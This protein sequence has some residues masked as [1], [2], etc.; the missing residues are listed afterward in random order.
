MNAENSSMTPGDADSVNDNE[1]WLRRLGKK[2]SG[3][4]GDRE[5]IKR[6]LTEARDEQVID[7]EDLGMMIGVLEVAEEQVRD[8]MIPRAQ[9][10]VLEADMA[11]DE[12]LRTV[13][14]SGHSRFPVIAENR[15]Q[16]GGILLAKDLLRYALNHQ[17]ESN[18]DF[19]IEKLLR[20]AVF[21]PESKRLNVLLKQFKANR[22]HM[23]I[24]LDEYGGV[25]GLVTIE[26]VLEQIVGEIDDEHDSAEGAYILRQDDTK[27][28]VRGLTP[29]ADFNEH[30]GTQFPDDEFDTVAGMVIHQFAHLPKRGELI[31]ID[32]FRFQV[33][34]AD[35]R[36]VH[37]LLVTVLAQD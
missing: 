29:I 32:R 21:V 25:A 9:M 7:A 26:D 6:V 16:V 35:T 20:E 34:R 23:A 13:V 19:D 22:Q 12:L 8:I 1:G 36:R 30:F 31:E 10:V 37:L 11:F 2:L 33:Q 3:P 28:L 27:Y 18:Q 5:E 4:P 15:D 17:G 14:E 24:V